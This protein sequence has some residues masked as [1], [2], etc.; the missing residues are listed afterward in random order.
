[1]RVC[2]TMVNKVH[3]SSKKGMMKLLNHKFN[4]KFEK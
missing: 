3:K 1:M 2:A 4:K